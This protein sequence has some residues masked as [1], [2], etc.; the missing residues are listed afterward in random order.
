MLRLSNDYDDFIY[1]LSKTH[2]RESKIQT[3][4]VSSISNVKSDGLELD[5]FECQLRN[6]FSRIETEITAIDAFCEELSL[7]QL[8]LEYLNLDSD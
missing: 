3:Q 7:D 6:D 2:E 5:Q 4:P 8:N 1:I